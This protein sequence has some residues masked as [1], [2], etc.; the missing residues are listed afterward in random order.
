L[1]AGPG[2]GRACALVELHKTHPYSQL[3]ARRRA[4]ADSA[5]PEAAI[6]P[7][8]P[9]FSLLAAA[10]DE[11]AK[12]EGG[13]PARAIPLLSARHIHE[14]PLTAALFDARGAAP[15]SPGQPAAERPRRERQRRQRVLVVPEAA[16]SPVLSGRRELVERHGIR[17]V[18]GLGGSL[19]GRDL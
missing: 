3:D 16:V 10:G 11:P 13:A 18:L 7:D 9:C 19:L 5:A 6:P 14:R 17:T 2:G 4:A 1:L 12:G 15:L 8:T